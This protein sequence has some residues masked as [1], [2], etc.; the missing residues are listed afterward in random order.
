MGCSASVAS[1]DQLDI[2][3]KNKDLENEL[4]QHASKEAMKFKLLLLGAG[5][6]GK[7]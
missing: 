5:E 4:K 1:E 2:K 7:R 6:S 3:K